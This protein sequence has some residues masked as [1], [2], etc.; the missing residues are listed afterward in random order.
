MAAV[1]QAYQYL[2]KLH[3]IDYLPL[4]SDNATN[5]CKNHLSHLDFV[6]SDDICLDYSL[7]MSSSEVDGCN[8]YLTC[9]HNYEAP[10]Y[11]TCKMTMKEMKTNVDYYQV[12]ICSID[13]LSSS[14]SQIR[15]NY[16]RYFKEIKAIPFL[17]IEALTGEW[18]CSL[19]RREASSL[20]FDCEPFLNYCQRVDDCLKILKPKCIRGR[21][22]NKLTSGVYNNLPIQTF[23]T[24][25][26]GHAEA[27]ATCLGRV[28]TAYT[29]LLD[30]LQFPNTIL[31][32]RSLGKLYCYW[33]PG[34][35]YLDSRHSI[36]I[37]SMWWS[38]IHSQCNTLGNCINA[39]MHEIKAREVCSADQQ[40]Q[41]GEEDTDEV[42]GYRVLQMLNPAIPL[43]M[44]LTSSNFKF[45]F[46]NVSLRYHPYIDETCDHLIKDITPYHIKSKRQL[47][48]GFVCS[49]DKRNLTCDSFEKRCSLLKRCMEDSQSQCQPISERIVS[50]GLIGTSNSVIE[51]NV[52]ACLQDLQFTDIHVF[53][54][55]FRTF[56]KLP[57]LDLTCAPKNNRDCNRFEERCNRTTKCLL[58]QS[59]ARCEFR[60]RSRALKYFFRRWKTFEKPSVIQ[61]CNRRHGSRH[62]ITMQ[63]MSLEKAEILFVLRS[64]LLTVDAD[65]FKKRFLK[66]KNRFPAGWECDRGYNYQHSCREYLQICADIAKCIMKTNVSVAE[67]ERDKNQF[68]VRTI[69]GHQCFASEVGP[70]V[71]SLTFQGMNSYQVSPNKF[72]DSMIKIINDIRFTG[73][74][75][76][77]LA[78]MKCL[79]I[80]IA[81]CQDSVDDACMEQITTVL[82]EC[83]LMIL[84]S[85]SNVD[86]QVVY[87]LG[88]VFIKCCPPNVAWSGF[89]CEH[90]AAACNKVLKCFNNGRKFVIPSQ[91]KMAAILSNKPLHYS[92]FGS[93]LFSILVDIFMKYK[94][95]QNL[96]P[97]TFCIN[98]LISGWRFHRSLSE[99]MSWRLSILSRLYIRWVFQGIIPILVYSLSYIRTFLNISRE[100][101]IH[102][103]LKSSA[104]Q[105]KEKR[106][107]SNSFC[108]L[109]AIIMNI[110]RV[111]LDRSIY[112]SYCSILSGAVSDPLHFVSRSTHVK[113]MADIHSSVLTGQRELSDSLFIYHP[114]CFE[115]SLLLSQPWAFFGYFIGVDFFVLYMVPLILKFANVY[116]IVTNVRESNEFRRRANVPLISL[117]KK[118]FIKLLGE[119]VTMFIL[120]VSHLIVTIVIVWQDPQAYFLDKTFALMKYSYFLVLLLFSICTRV[121]MFACKLVD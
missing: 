43:H 70:L 38:I 116:L 105:A 59:F 27:T 77:K 22:R 72:S 91:M 92:L 21:I 75:S 7:A 53:D 110:P 78:F 15:S 41:G 82:A 55:V 5:F 28:R 115:V 26:S 107:L 57:S 100:L 36:K 104:G 44:G 111:M 6:T 37:F 99:N 81:E 3:S 83:R 4:I 74:F 118:N 51:R 89:S 80:Y 14:S 10:D 73:Q 97:L 47:L 35:I 39:T 67:R 71:M 120:F 69:R 114:D 60:G 42:R 24:W 45:V 121:M 2:D 66:F 63:H 109:L 8:S 9:L 12:A 58:K 106:P 25:R 30:H 79:S 18:S 23:G 87:E 102:T 46:F 108:L 16:L 61:Y 34:L 68:S 101:E 20:G 29:Y 49:K 48:L 98:I 117:C 93:L 65:M 103:T 17:Q 50:A 1:C 64:K 31:A 113:K 86:L 112:A 88:K 90:W 52:D 62:S 19:T 119:V 96:C 95:S 54:L 32:K 33:Q 76:N 11:H 85:V 56:E 84:G 13:A 40:A 94:Y